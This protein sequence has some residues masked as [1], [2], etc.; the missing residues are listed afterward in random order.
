[1]RVYIVIPAYN[2]APYLSATLES[3]TTQTYLPTKICVVDDNSTDGTSE[4]IKKFTSQHDFISTCKTDFENKHLPG[5]KVVHTF[6]YGLAS[7]DNNYDLI[8]KFDAD[9]IFPENYIETIVQAFAINPNLGIAGG[10]CYIEKKGKWVLENLTGPDHIRGALKC[11]RKDCFKEIGGLIPAMG[12][13]TLDELLALFYK[14]ELQ[15][16]TD[17]HVKHLKPTGQNYHKGSRFNQGYAFYQMRYRWL[18]TFLAAAKLSVRRKSFKY[19]S[20]CII[21]FVRAFFIR[22]PFLVTKEQGRFIRGL[23]WKTISKTYLK[24]GKAKEVSS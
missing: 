21:G 19:F 1:M 23:R 9:L 5:S 16:L 7:L 15:T 2:E 24:L 14:W 8:C 6:H 22:K 20:N 4:I 12:W 13:D 17:L 10:F 3:L 11:Y 18:L